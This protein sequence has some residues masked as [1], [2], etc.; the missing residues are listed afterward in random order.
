VITAKQLML[1]GSWEQT[2]FHCLFLAA[3][4]HQP[5]ALE[6]GGQTASCRNEK[7]ARSAAQQW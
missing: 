1:Q 6:A 4:Q 5:A 3:L 7:E 2:Q